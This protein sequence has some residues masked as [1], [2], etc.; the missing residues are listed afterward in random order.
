MKSPDIAHGSFTIERIY[1]AEPARVFEAWA[2]PQ[3]KSRWFIG[4]GDWTPLERALDF[5]VG[6]QELLRGRRGSME[7]LFTARFHSIVPDERIVYV[8]DMH[9]SGKHHSLSLAT[10]EITSAGSGAKLV[11]TEQVAYLDGTSGADG[12]AS[13]KHGT[14]GHLD[15]LAG[16][17]NSADENVSAL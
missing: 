2:D 13:R 9:L 4:P 3:I 17:F 14:A 16:Q 6:G 11:F 5:R 1:N 10:V 15:R 8:Y 12:T 7:T